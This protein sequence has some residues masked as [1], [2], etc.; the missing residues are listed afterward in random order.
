MD[1]GKKSDQ[2]ALHSQ[3]R[4][5]TQ[6]KQ[7]TRLPWQDRA[8]AYYEDYVKRCEVLSVESASVDSI[9]SSCSFLSKRADS[10][11]NSLMRAS[12]VAFKKNSLR[13]AFCLGDFCTVI[14][15]Y[16]NNICPP[17]KKLL[18]RLKPGK[19]RRKSSPAC[20]GHEPNMN[21]SP[22]PDIRLTTFQTCRGKAS[23]LHE[24]IITYI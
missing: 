22:F 5:F 15:I 2:T 17:F 18:H 11:P 21:E 3:S 4:L 1:S 8:Y 24:I 14:L 7:G 13:S 6:P 10:R 16:D 19:K 23:A 12:R 9:P 20:A